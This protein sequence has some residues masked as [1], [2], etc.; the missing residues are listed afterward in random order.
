MANVMTFKR[1]EIETIVL[2][3]YPTDSWTVESNVPRHMTRLFK[4]VD[5]DKI[6]VLCTDKNGRPTQIRAK[7]LKKLITFRNTKERE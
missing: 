4:V 3:E 2:Y 6:E 5:A 7:G 1:E